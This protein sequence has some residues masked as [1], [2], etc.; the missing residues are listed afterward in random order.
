MACGR[1]LL[2]RQGDPTHSHLASSSYSEG[3]TLQVAPSLFVF[4]LPPSDIKRQVGITDALYSAILFQKVSLIPG[5]NN[6]RSVHGQLSVSPRTALRPP[7]TALRPFTDSTPSAHGQHSVR[8]RTALHQPTDSSPSVHG[9]HSIRPWTEWNQKKRGRVHFDTP[10]SPPPKK[11]GRGL[12][13]ERPRSLTQMT[14][15][16]HA[17]DRGHFSPLCMLSF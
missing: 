7:R 17:R 5:G 4:A 8:P 9:Q 12:S 15:V 16:F 14:A 10:S 6:K 2:P 13:S 11:K 1:I 3:A